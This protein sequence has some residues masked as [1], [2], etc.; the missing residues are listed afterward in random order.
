[1]ALSLQLHLSL[2][3]EITKRIFDWVREFDRREAMDRAAAHAILWSEEW[4]NIMGDVRSN[5]PR[6]TVILETQS[7]YRLRM[8]VFTPDCNPVVWQARSLGSSFLH[9]RRRALSVC[10]TER[11]TALL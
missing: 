10:L 8:S 6:Y 11:D 9:Y 2:P 1:M 7:G 4:A 3:Y 5:T